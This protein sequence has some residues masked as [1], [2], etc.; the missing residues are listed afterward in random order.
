L[1]AGCTVPRHRARPD[2]VRSLS[3]GA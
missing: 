2:A 3:R 1:P